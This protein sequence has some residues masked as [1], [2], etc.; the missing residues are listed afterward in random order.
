VWGDHGYHLG[1]QGLW[2]K[3][4]NYELSTRVPLVI[5]VPGIARAKTKALVELVDIYPT[6]ADICGLDAPMGVEGISLKPLLAD[7]DRAWKQAVFSQY[8]R[9][10]NGHRHRGHGDIMGYAVRTDRRRYVEWRPWKSTR[11]IAR[12]LYDH[13]TDARESRNLAMQ[14]ERAGEVEEL[15][16]ILAGGWKSSLPIANEKAR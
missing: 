2:T 3:A 10:R 6:L 9:A 5:S 13:D 7:P 11:V 14:A 1:E 4:N 15:S 12:E 8:P 16:R